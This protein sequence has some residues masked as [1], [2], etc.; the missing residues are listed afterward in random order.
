MLAD[1]IVPRTQ[2]VSP[3]RA[4]ASS[5]VMQFDAVAGGAA[6]GV[7]F[8]A[9]GVDCAR[10][11]ML[12][13]ANA[14]AVAVGVGLPM[15]IVTEIGAQAASEIATMQ[16]EKARLILI[17]TAARI[18]VNLFFKFWLTLRLRVGGVR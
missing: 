12:G 5:Q 8:F 4:L 14:I 1:E 15:L 10:G 9:A 11:A 3:M 6:T 16:N 13:A 17:P 18:A 7:A 2:T